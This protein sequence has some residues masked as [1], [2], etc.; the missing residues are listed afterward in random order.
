MV[1]YYG[2]LVFDTTKPDGKPRKLA[3]AGRLKSLG[4]KNK[5]G[6]QQGLRRTF[7]FYE[8]SH[9]SRRMKG[10][11]AQFGK[12]YEYENGISYQCT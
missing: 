4:W 10:G 11:T 5:I 9:H 3:D 12:E 2:A 8:Q 6:V 1:S 7:E